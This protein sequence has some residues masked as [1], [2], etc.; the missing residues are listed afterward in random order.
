MANYRRALDLSPISGKYL[1]SA[2]F[3][4]YDLRRMND[5]RQY[6]ERAIGVDPRSAD[7]YAGAGMTALAL[8]DRAQAKADAAR[9]RALDPA[10]HALKTLESQL[11]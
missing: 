3:Q 8:G 9:S 5:A 6:F 2:G 7:A 11:R 10:A 4:A 1:V